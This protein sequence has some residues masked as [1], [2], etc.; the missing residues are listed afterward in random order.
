MSDLVERL[1]EIA[2]E[3]TYCNGLMCAA[4]S[5]MEDAADRIEELE[6]ML[7][8]KSDTCNFYKAS[9]E[10]LEVEVRELN[11]CELDL[12]KRL[13]AAEDDNERLRAEIKNAFF[14]GHKCAYHTAEGEK[15][16]CWNRS[17]A[18]AAVKEA[19]DD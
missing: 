3:Q 8:T 16:G 15:P 18:L 19:S 4:E 5:W 1:R 9:V 6:C 2:N 10:E 11:E 13:D 17:K 14:E 12:L 7:Q